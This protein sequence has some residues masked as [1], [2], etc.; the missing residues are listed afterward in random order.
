MFIWV[1]GMISFSGF[2]VLYNS[3]TIDPLHK[4]IITKTNKICCC[5]SKKKIFEFENI[6]KIL[7]EKD[8]D[9]T[10]KEDNDHDDYFKIEF[11]LQTNEVIDILTGVRDRDN[12]ESRKAYFIMRNA[13]PSNF[14]F[15]GDINMQL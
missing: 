3:I 4:V 1:I 15:G 14:L 2:T 8:E 12:N 13:L 7:I 11:L 5:F 9:V 10:F 6:K